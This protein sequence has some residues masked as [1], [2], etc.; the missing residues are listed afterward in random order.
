LDRTPKRVT[1]HNRQ[2]EHSHNWAA[3][4]VHGFPLSD[5]LN[6]HKTHKACR[7]DHRALK[8]RDAQIAKPGLQTKTKTAC[9]STMLQARR[10]D[11]NR[12]PT[13]ES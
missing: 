13:A 12:S 6:G 2:Q 11:F 9:S 5:K 3:R 7:K 10:D 8:T 4:F 1:T